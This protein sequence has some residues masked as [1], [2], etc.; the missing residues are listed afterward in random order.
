[1]TKA[2][3]RTKGSEATKEQKLDDAEVLALLFEMEDSAEHFPGERDDAHWAQLQINK[4][5]QKIRE[6]NEEIAKQKAYISKYKHLI[7]N[8]KRCIVR[9]KN[10]NKRGRPART[11]HREKAVRE[12][13]QKWVASLMEALEAK[14]CGAQR[15][16]EKMVS[17][18]QERNWR[19]WLSGEAIPTYATFDNLL[20][21]V[22]TSG[23]YAGEPLFKVP[24]T[25]THNQVLTLLQFI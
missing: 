14:G 21:T 11:K 23:K 6:L 12:F 18:E 17:S 22:I 3:Y 24:V 15:G 16:L 19:R 1:M 4:A 20:D 10:L 5:D 9:T 7:Q 13:M 2:A 8:Y 25:P